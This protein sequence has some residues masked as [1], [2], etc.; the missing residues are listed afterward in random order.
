M[1]CY[2]KLKLHAWLKETPLCCCTVTADF[3]GVIAG[4]YACACYIHSLIFFFF[5]VQKVVCCFV[6]INLASRAIYLLSSPPSPQNSIA[7]R[8]HWKALA[9]LLTYCSTGK[10]MGFPYMFCQVAKKKAMIFRGGD[11][12]PFLGF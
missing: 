11:G 9:D 7:G 8:D 12:T 5:W 1:S 3:S 4:K 6:G 10:E 2:N